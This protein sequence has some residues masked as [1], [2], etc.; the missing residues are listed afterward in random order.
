MWSAGALFGSTEICRAAGRTKW[1][2]TNDNHANNKSQDSNNLKYVG[3][4]QARFARSLL[5][6]AS[7][8]PNYPF[9]AIEV[10]RFSIGAAHPRTGAVLSCFV[11]T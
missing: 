3:M 4:Y 7:E 8:L 2:A 10:V 6:L 11:K 9:D 1:R 5:Q